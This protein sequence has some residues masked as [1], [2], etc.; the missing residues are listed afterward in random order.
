MFLTYYFKVSQFLSVLHFTVQAS[1]ADALKKRA[2][3]FGTPASVAS[4]TVVSLPVGNIL[5][6]VWHDIC[7]K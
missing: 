6:L 5:C 1:S 7:V 3:R 4:S 2:E